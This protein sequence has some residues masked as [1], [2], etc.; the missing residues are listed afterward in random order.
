QIMLLATRPRAVRYN[1][2]FAIG[3][4][5]G[6]EEWK[7]L[8]GEHKVTQDIGLDLQIVAV[9]GALVRQS[10]EGLLSNSTLASFCARA[11]REASAGGHA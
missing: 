9:T 4:L 6:N 5:G 8:L 1:A 7:E 10:H 11:L 3:G 2:G